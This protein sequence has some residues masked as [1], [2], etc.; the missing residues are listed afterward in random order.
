MNFRL[1]NVL[2]AS[3]SEKWE[4]VSS[5][6]LALLGLI[7]L[8]VYAAEVVISLD[9]VVP[10]FLTMISSAIWLVFALDVII[11]FVGSGSLLKFLRGSWLEVAA[12]LIPFVRFLRV[13]RV[14]LALR[15]IKGF[16]GDRASAAGIYLLLLV[17]LT[18]FSGAI[19]V[20]EA[21]SGNPDA[22]I[23]T[24]RDALW[25]SLTTITTVGYG[26][27]YPSSVEGQLVAGVLMLTG[28]A[29]FSAGA[30]IF[31]SWILQEKRSS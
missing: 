27:S 11:R 8:G 20:L 13:F 21:E 18:W 22:N 9:N 7:Y 25:W 1:T 24:L 29:L 2:N 12:L 3:V 31:A 17:P 10:P 28:I 4:K 26:D 15:A 5:L 6:P 23:T 14:I 19:A 30:G 16:I